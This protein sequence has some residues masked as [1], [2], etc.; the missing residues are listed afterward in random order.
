MIKYFSIFK[1]RHFFTFSFMFFYKIRVYNYCCKEKNVR[2]V[3]RYLLNSVE[4]K[5]ANAEITIRALLN[6]VLNEVRKDAQSEVSEAHRNF[7]ES[8]LTEKAS[9]GS[10]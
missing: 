6:K 9:R 4:S 1:F 7:H 3:K 5:F 2:E 8:H 10:G